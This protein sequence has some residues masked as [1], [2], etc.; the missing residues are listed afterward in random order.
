MKR[1]LGIIILSAVSFSTYSQ[2]ESGY[3]NFAIKFSPTQLAAGEFNFSYE[4]RVAR[5]ISLELELG[6]TISQFGSN[7]GNQKLWQGDLGLWDFDAIDKNAFASVGFHV[8]LAPR[9]YPSFDDGQMKGLYLSPVFKFR[10]YNYTNKFDML[11][12]ARSSI[13]QFIFRFNMG[14]QFWP[15]DGKFSI[16]MYFGLGL[17]TFNIKG[18]RVGEYENPPGSGNVVPR[19]ETYRD[20]GIRINAITGIKFGFGN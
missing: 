9:F 19:W 8:S 1:L 12:N 17:G 11:D 3:R 2:N 13:S 6:P 15:G 18:Q 14:L 4:Q 5:L 10:Q 20:N 16:D 7:F